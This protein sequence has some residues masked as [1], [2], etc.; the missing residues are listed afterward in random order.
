MKTPGAI[1]LTKPKT[2]NLFP[3]RRPAQVTE[4][5][6]EDDEAD[7]HHGIGSPKRHTDSQIEY[8]YQKE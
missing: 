3:Q 6:G 1:R 5:G 4:N 2:L 8:E 7:T